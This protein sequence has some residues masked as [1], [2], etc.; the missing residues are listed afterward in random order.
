MNNYQEIHTKAIV[1]DTHNDILSLIL[2][3]GY[4]L[5]DDLKGKTHSDLK[6]WNEGGLNVQVFSVWCDGNKKDP[7]LHAIKQM[8]TLDQCVNNNPKKIV[9]VKNSDRLEKA[10]REGKIAALFGIEGGHMI[11]DDLSKIDQFYN[12]GARYITLTWN[13]STA[14][15]SSAFDEEYSTILKHK[16][17]SEFGY[18]VISRMNAL[19][20]MID[21]SHAGEQTFWDVIQTSTKPIIASHSCVYSICPTQRNL[22]DDQIK[23]IAKNEGVIQVNFYSE[24]LESSFKENKENFFLKHKEEMEEL[25][26]S[27]MIIYFAEEFLFSKYRAEIDEI[28]APLSLLI[29]HIVYIIDLVGIEYVGLGSDFDGMLAPPKQL[30]D[31]SSYPLITKALIERDYSE[32]DIIKI[33]GGNFLRVLKA[34]EN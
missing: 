24:F 30:D 32:N 18:K 34:N 2:E 5:N 27:G 7:F 4:N 11:E 9:E 28:R 33:L 16:G 6:R 22:K 8:D 23:A 31:V 1:V 19:G 12:R 20:M 17:L 14:W 3:K 15:A 26:K 29:D 25:L 10:I 21:V 13:N